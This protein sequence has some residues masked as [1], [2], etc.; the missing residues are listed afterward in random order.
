MR[1][2]AALSLAFGLAVTAAAAQPVPPADSAPGEAV[3][4]FSGRGWGHGVGMSQYGAFGQAKEG[5]TYDQILAYYYSGTQVGRAATK[6]VRVLLAEGRRAI[7]VFSASPFRAVDAAG[8]VTKLPAGALVLTPELRLAQSANPS[9]GP[10]VIRAGKAPVALD[11]VSYRGRFE[12]TAQ[13]GFLRVVN[14]VSLEDYIQ[15]VVADE[16]PHSW[17]LE[18]LKAQ[19]VAARSYALKNVLKGKPYDLYADQRS[20]VYGGIASEQPASTAAV[21]ATAGR[22]VTYGGQIASTYYFSTS[23]GK[24]ASA[25]DVFGFSVPY[26][27]SRPDPWDKASPY[28]RWGPVLVGA[29]TV[30]AKLSAPSRVLDAASVSTPSGR[31]RSLTLRTLTGSTSVPSSLVRTALGLRST[32]ITIG[33]L[34]LDRPR[35]ASAV[36]FGSTLQLVGVARNVVAP[37][38]AASVAGA[39]WA[40]VGALERGSDGAV[41]R[42]VQPTKMTRYRIEGSGTPGQVV[43]QVLLVRV[44]PR[45]RLTRPAEPGV[46]TGTVRPRLPGALVRI[47]RQR[48]SGWALVDEVIAD[49]AGAFRAEIDLISGTYRARVAA[50]GGYVEGISPVL[51]VAG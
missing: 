3:F 26:L 5:R 34:R 30:Q 22:V 38:L 25:L 8:V 14:H 19:A 13:G 4:V 44:A 50:A 49:R 17:P 29:R 1:L 45:V 24:T 43:S 46:L 27:V 42:S 9:T 11:G 6:E 51:A 36:E 47:E 31:L 32:W 10:V 39:T 28:H 21:R 35:G 41:S 2:L 37:Q 40:P 48:G 20:Q 33:V 16:M 7:T 18:A 15:G 12:V 23:G